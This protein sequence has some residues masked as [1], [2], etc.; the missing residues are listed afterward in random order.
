MSLNAK[1]MILIVNRVINSN[2]HNLNHKL[3][4]KHTIMYTILHKILINLIK[5]SCEINNFIKN[6]TEKVHLGI[7]IMQIILNESL[8][9]FLVK[10][11]KEPN[12]N[13][14]INTMINMLVNNGMIFIESFKNMNNM[15]GM[16]KKEN[17]SMKIIETTSNKKCS[18]KKPMKR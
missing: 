2:I 8:R 5:I 14:N 18:N 16:N 7:L 6:K 1:S 17:I 9:L 3:T 4:N 10:K 13:K 12:I 11:N 15:T